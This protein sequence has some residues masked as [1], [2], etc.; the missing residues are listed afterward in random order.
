MLSRAIN[1]FVD[2]LYIEVNV[3]KYLSVGKVSVYGLI[4][5]VGGR[6]SFQE[7]GYISNILFRSHTVK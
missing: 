3:Y 6:F 7:V 1:I 2:G 4:S 5:L